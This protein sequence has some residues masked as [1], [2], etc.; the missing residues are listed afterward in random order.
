M[1]ITK[2]DYLKGEYMIEMLIGLFSGVFTATGMGGGTILI[3]LLSFLLKIE[4]HEAQAANVIFY[5]P[6]AVFAIIFSIKNKMV[7]FKLSKIIIIFGIVGAI[8]GAMISSKM[9]V[10]LLKKVFGFFLLFI[11][12]Y[13]IYKWYVTYIKQKK[14]HNKN[15]E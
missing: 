14:E 13:E 2:N 12:C 10:N 8:I 9:E 11:S 5:I 7:D 15:K 3:L 6:T 4:Q 1:C